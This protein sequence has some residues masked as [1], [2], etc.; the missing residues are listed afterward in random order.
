MSRPRLDL[1]LYLVTD[2][3][4]L[5]GRDLLDVVGQA[6]AGGAGLVQLREKTA[7]TREFVELAR[8]VAGILRPRG[9]P[10]LIN[11]RVDVALAAGADG[12]HV[13]QDDMRPA[14]VR[15]ILGPDALIG[16]SVTGE[17]EA[18]AARGEPVDYL[19][20]GPVFAT[21]TK[22]DA[23]AAQGLAGLAAMIALAE[24]PVVAIGAIT[25][26]NAASVLDQGAAGLAVVSAI[27]SAPNPR[28][29]AARLRRIVDGVRPG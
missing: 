21:A 15:A 12:V 29:A 13:G 19:G 7:S 10:L 18:R 20:A 26:A 9:V 2:R 1:G 6:V 28:E 17:A 25:S 24:V 8:A 23:G 3:P 5:L 16:L 14:D 11:D 27:C 4:A 22:P